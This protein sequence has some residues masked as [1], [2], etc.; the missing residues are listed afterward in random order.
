MVTFKQGILSGSD[1]LNTSKGE[2]FLNRLEKEQAVIM[3]Q[4]QLQ[5][6]KFL[7]KELF[8]AI[9]KQVDTEIKPKINA[10][11]QNIGSAS[12]AEPGST[13]SSDANK[14]DFRDLKRDLENIQ[15]THSENFP[16]ELVYQKLFDVTFQMSELLVFVTRQVSQNAQLFAIA[17]LKQTEIDLKELKNELNNE[18]NQARDSRNEQESA[19]IKAESLNTIMKE[20]LASA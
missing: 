5:N 2:E 10:M 6:R 3:S 15:A 4:I 7:S 13:T 17:R 12:G 19:L 8:D 18:R 11:L 9:Q 14:Y 20:K 1:F 16:P